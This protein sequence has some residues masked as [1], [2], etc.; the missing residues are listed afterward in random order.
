MQRDWRG[1]KKVID[2]DCKWLQRDC[3]RLQG[4]FKGSRFFKPNLVL[5][6]ILWE[7]SRSMP[8]F[9]TQ[10]RELIRN[11]KN[12]LEDLRGRKLAN[13]VYVL[14]KKRDIW[15]KELYEARRTE[16]KLLRFGGCFQANC[17]LPLGLRGWKQTGRGC[18]WTYFYRVK[19]NPLF[20]SSLTQNSL[21]LSPFLLPLQYH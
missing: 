15:G 5:S 1:C 17:V 21:S 10:S 19:V 18:P 8:I 13:F 7:I 16:D 14:T 12:K 2:R 20:S 9:L 4:D 3:K 6:T 11:Y